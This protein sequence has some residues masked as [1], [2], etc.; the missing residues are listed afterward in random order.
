MSESFLWYDL[1]TW[2]RDPRRTRIAQFAAQR[3]DDALQPLGAPEVVFVRPALDLLPSPTAALITGLSPFDLE[4]RGVL[5]A[6]AFRGIA[7]CFAE[8]GT[9]GV[10]WNSLRFDDEFLRFGL[11]RNF[12]D[13]YQREYEAGN[14]RWDLLDF[15]RLL[16]ALRPDGIEWP[17]RED[18][19]PSFRLEHLAA[20]NGVAHTS[21]HDALS[22]VEATIGLA[23]RF[24]A[25]Q[26]KLWNYHLGFRRKD[27]ARPLLDPA[28]AT[29]V[30]HVSGR[31]P[32]ERGCASIVLP[33]ALHPAVGNQVI[34]ADLF[35][36][37]APLLE[38]DAGELAERLF[39][40]WADLPEGESRP[41]LKTVHLNRCPAL[42]ELAHVRDAELE[43]LGIDRTRCLDHGRR[44]AAD[45]EL[46]ERVRRAFARPAAPL[47]ADVDQ[48]LYD[49]L[50]DRRDARLMQQIRRAGPAEL[51]GLHGRF[52]DPRGDELLFRYRGRNWPDSLLPDE[53]ARWRAYRETRL[54]SDDDLSEY[55][56]ASFDVEIDQ[57]TA[58]RSGDAAALALLAELR[59]WGRHLETY[60]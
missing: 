26:P 42:I 23:R 18:G 25:A 11:Y 5:E 10:G 47:G 24:R 60:P 3:T 4:R 30:L 57:L 32:A 41:P 8:P 7:A 45:R 20:A 34:V 1:E 35:A 54:A 12:H 39:I 2:G 22:D 44:L 16:Y 14:S 17:R 27:R 58:Q 31:F 49:A 55:S 51:A 36:D 50:P 53:A 6:E 33:L 21:A 28:K 15:A 13:P 52:H 19:A 59:D 48:A 46:A 56:F 38:L 37:P 29:P 9:C 43:R 40:A